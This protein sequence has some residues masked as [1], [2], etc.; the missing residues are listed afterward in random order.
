[1]MLVVSISM[2][3]HEYTVDPINML[4]QKQNPIQAEWNQICQPWTMPNPWMPQCYYR[5]TAR[6]TGWIWISIISVWC[7]YGMHGCIPILEF[8]SFVISTHT[9]PQLESHPSSIENSFGF[10]LNWDQKHWTHIKWKTS[11]S[12][13]GICKIAS[14]ETD[15]I[16]MH[17]TVYT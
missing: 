13:Y 10:C 15:S 4:E 17:C 9:H 8:K 5:H 14:T 16:L 12:V 3:D 11:F 7:I 1:M 6:K 2:L